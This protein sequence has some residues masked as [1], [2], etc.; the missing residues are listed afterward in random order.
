MS[1][2]CHVYE[3]SQGVVPAP[4]SWLLWRLFTRASLWKWPAVTEGDETAGHFLCWASVPVLQARFEQAR[5]TAGQGTILQWKAQYSR[6]VKTETIKKR[7][8]DP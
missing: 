2:Y 7:K 4:P 3:D 1:E 5:L 8:V 6:S